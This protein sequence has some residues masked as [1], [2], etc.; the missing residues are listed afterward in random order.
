MVSNQI[1]SEILQSYQQRLQVYLDS[2]A[3][4]Y[5]DYS[6]L[7]Q[8]VAARLFER[9]EMMNLQPNRVLDVGC[10]IGQLTQELTNK[11]PKAKILG[12]DPSKK[13]LKQAKQAYGLFSPVSF[14]QGDADKLPV[15][16]KSM[17][18]VISNLNYDYHLDKTPIFL[19]FNRVLK[20]GGLL[21]FSALGPDSFQEL[22]QTWQ[23]IDS[24]AQFQTFYDMHIIGDQ[25]Q[26]A[27]FENTLMDRDLIQLNY[28]TVKGL[29]KELKRAGGKNLLYPA[30][31]LWGKTKFQRFEQ[32]FDALR[33]PEG[34]LPVTCEL[35][36]GHAWKKAD[37]S[38]AD[39]HTYQ[40]D[41]KAE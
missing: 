23:T 24:K 16:N 39:Y 17:D 26:A 8:E 22:R 18:L 34:H 38:T 12:I 13:M 36:F 9:L 1:P 35:I 33:N 21:I 29:L 15:K 5:A 25:V 7:Q 2:I 28:Q 37:A 40:V 4:D 31:G 32:A 20:P 14:K 27:A 11:F 41:L 30:K 3:A 19:E 10:R 6:F